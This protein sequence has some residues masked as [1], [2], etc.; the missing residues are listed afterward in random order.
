MTVGLVSSSNGSVLSRTREAIQFALENDFS[1]TIIEGDA[2]SLFEEAAAAVKKLQ[3][4]EV[5][6]SCA[7]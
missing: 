3:D 6:C 1:T 4:S 5:T 7:S 2:K